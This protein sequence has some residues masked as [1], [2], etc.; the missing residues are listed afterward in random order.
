MDY[1][2]STIWDCA[3]FLLVPLNAPRIHALALTAVCALVAALCLRPAAP[4]DLR[5]SMFDVGQGTGCAYQSTNGDWLVFD[6][7]PGSDALAQSLRYY[8]VNRIDTIVLSHGDADHIGGL[9]HLLRD[10]HVKQLIAS[11]AAQT[12]EEW[13]MLTPYLKDTAIINANRALTFHADG[14]SLECILRDIGTDDK[15]NA[16]QVIGP[17]DRQQQH[18]LSLYRRQ[19]RRYLNES[20]MA[21]ANGCDYCPSPW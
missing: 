13:Q 18:K 2:V 11:P 15:E 20:A 4:A 1:C 19:Q 7:G 16:N 12:S 3:L 21:G 17:F 5:L 8:G 9:A 6:T 10:F 14:L